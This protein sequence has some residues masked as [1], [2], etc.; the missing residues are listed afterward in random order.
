M[1]W[2]PSGLDATTLT[3]TCPGTPTTCD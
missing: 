3:V 1:I 2:T